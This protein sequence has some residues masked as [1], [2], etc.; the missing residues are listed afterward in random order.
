M[1]TS[2]AAQDIICAVSE[3]RGVSSTIGLAFVNLATAEAVLCQI[4]D[5][6][7][8]VKTIIK[9]GVFEPSEIL[10]MNTAKESK[11]RYIIQ[12]NL[13]DPIFTFLDR[14][15]WSEKTGHEYVERMAFPEEVDSLKV[16]LGGNYFAACCF[17]AVLKYV[18]VELQ[19]SFTAHSLRIRFEPS[20]GSM[21]IDLATIVS[22]E[23]IQ[24]LQNA[25]SKESLFG[26]LN[27]TLTTMGARLLRA[28][29]LQPSTERVKLTARYNAVEDLATKEDMFVSVRQALKGF[30]DAD[31][32]LTAIILVPTKRTIQYVEQSVNNV[33]MLKTYVSSIK[34]IFQALGAAQSD[35]LLTIRE[36]CAPEGYRS[37]EDLINT[38]LN[39]NVAY[40]SKPLDL[41]N[42]RIYCVKAGVNSL[43][44]VARQTYKEANSDAIELIEKL[45]GMFEVNCD[46]VLDLKYDTARQY[47]ICIPATE[48]GPLPDVFINVYRKR[49]CIECQTLDLV[50]LNQ[51]IT[52]AHSEVINI[53]DQTIQDLL[54]DVCTEVS[55]L[56]RVS[57]AIA[58]LDMLAAFAQL[59]TNYDYIRP[60]LTDT[61]A[62]KAGRHPI[63]EQIHNSKF[64]P[65]DAYATPQTRFQIITGCNMSGKSTYIRSLALVT[66]MAQVG[67]FIPAQYA[68]FPISHQLFA[69]IATSDDL[70]A[71]VSTF[72]AEMR[73]MA[74]ILRNIQ[75]RSMVIIDELGRGTSTTDGLAIAVALAEAL[76]SSNALVWFVTHF[77][78][79]A[80]I[81]AER[82]G[83]I[84]LHLAA[85]IA[86][87]ASKMT[88]QYRIAEGPVPDRRY[89]LVLAKLADLPP[90]VLN[91]A[92]SVSEAMDQLAKRRNSPSRAVAIAQKRKLLLSLREQLL[93]ARDGT[94]DK[95]SLRA[96]LI[97]LQ[98]DFVLR[99][100]AIN[101]EMEVYPGDESETEAPIEP[102]SNVSVHTRETH[103]LGS[104]ENNGRMDNTL[105]S[106][107]IVVDSDSDCEPEDVTDNDSVVL[108]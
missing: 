93:L 38:T 76:I 22:L 94:M 81:L 18:E 53:S 28:S 31:K 51:K 19:R 9:I 41:R 67:C 16:T 106:E 60:E 96:F 88:M 50:K 13:P 14:R 1:A 15:W 4:C 79:L 27:E 108:V 57:E 83:V 73:E 7:T 90:A 21:T 86:P 98:D 35:L 74:F 71:N 62:I 66:V 32:V 8:Y 78:D 61:L 54:R 45:S 29:I 40:Q 100:T 52:D 65:N 46:M 10:F 33:I 20:Q 92:R 24:N 42:Q 104:S 30:I 103:A 97:K 34:N 82:S 63:R 3:S 77:H 43:L 80:Q 2:V 101:R 99:M 72:A 47:Y 23:L 70:D 85:E 56:F 48:P 95:A 87:D 25:K 107:P 75:P 68:S 17:A 44:D 84:N 58:M 37:I 6:Q 11:L 89:G 26:L 49:K 12:E 36:L 55:G 105:V 91:K 102:V 5:S 69:R 39:E 59:A 64:I